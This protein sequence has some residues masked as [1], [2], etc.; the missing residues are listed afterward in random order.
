MW[1]LLA[2]QDLSFE[3]LLLSLILLLEVIKWDRLRE[4]GPSAYIIKFPVQA[5]EM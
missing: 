3:T 4:N 1:T 5:I 2:P